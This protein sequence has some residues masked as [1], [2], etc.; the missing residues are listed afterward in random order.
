MAKLI[1]NSIIESHNLR[2]NKVEALDSDIFDMIELHTFTTEDKIRGKR[3]SSRRIDPKKLEKCG[4][5]ARYIK[6]LVLAKARYGNLMDLPYSIGGLDE[7]FSGDD[8]YEWHEA[9]D[10]N[11][12]EQENKNK[13]FNGSKEGFKL[14]Y[15]L[16][17]NID[18]R[19]FDEDLADHIAAQIKPFY[20]KSSNTSAKIEI[21]AAEVAMNEFGESE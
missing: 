15:D 8:S 14:L 6:Q 19:V 11:F 18:F 7:K 20:K 9:L 1:R 5:R 2:E 4:D 12:W 16:I 21:D 13:V 17:K 10:T 3:D